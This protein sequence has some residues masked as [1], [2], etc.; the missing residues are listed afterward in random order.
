MQILWTIK[1]ICYSAFKQALPNQDLSLDDVEITLST[2]DKFG[3]YQCNSAM[4]FAKQLKLPPRDLAIKL[5]QIIEDLQQQNNLDLEFSSIDIAGAGFLNFT[6]STTSIAA[7]LSKQLQDPNCGVLQIEQPQK[8]VIDFSSPNIAKEMHVGHL[9]ST[10]IGDCIARIL[11]FVGYSV[12]RI[13]HLGDWGTQFGMLIAYLTTAYPNF[14]ESNFTLSLS[15]LMHIYKQSKEKFDLDPVFKQQ[16]QQAVIKLQSQDAKSYRIW[17]KICAISAQAY[18][19]I[20]DLL[21]IKIINRGES[22]YNPM[23][24]S[25][26]AELEQAQVLQIS[27][28]AKCIYLDGFKNRAGENLP[29]IVQKKDGGY[30]YATTDLAAIKHRVAQEQADWLIYVVD[31]GQIQHFSMVL[32]AAT[33]AQ[34]IDLKKITFTHV[35]FGLVLRADGKKF[36]TRSGDTEKLIDLIQIAIK[37]A[38]ELLLSRKLNVTAA[39]LASMASTLGVNAIKYADLANHRESDYKFSYDKMLQF[40]GNTAAFLLYAYVR[41]QSIKRKVADFVVPLTQQPI[42]INLVEPS[43]INLALHVCQFNDTVQATVRDLLPNRLTEYLFKLAEKF[44]VFFHYCRVEGSE[45]QASR[46]L[47]CESVAKVMEL[48]FGLLGLKLLYKM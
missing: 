35:S 46:L 36:K 39:E 45:S 48:G 40:E 32:A 17:E 5:K 43:E 16:S 42:N 11:E 3:H 14:E 2:Q 10:I 9:R 44:H 27:D 47:L 15:E 4:K 23:L 29:L 41:V 19:E 21:D 26:V 31:K 24:S 25:I 18:Q 20:Y 12:L 30:N 37:K 28:G 1:N 34:L 38:K 33:K 7:I 6:L 22:F 8:V 13:N